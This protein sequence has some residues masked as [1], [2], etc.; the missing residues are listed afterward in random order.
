MNVNPI[1]N[2]TAS[3]GRSSIERRSYAYNQQGEILTQ[4]HTN[5]RQVKNEIDEMEK[6]PLSSTHRY[7]SFFYSQSS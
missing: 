5:S 3:V 2:G 1:N 6:S 4:N 7:I